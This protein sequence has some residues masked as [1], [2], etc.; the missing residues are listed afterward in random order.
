MGEC[1]LHPQSA[2]LLKFNLWQA[3]H[4]QIAQRLQLNGRIGSSALVAC[5]E[6]MPTSRGLGQ[7]S[8]SFSGTRK[9]TL[10]HKNS[11]DHLGPQEDFVEHEKLFWNKMIMFGHIRML[12][13]DFNFFAYCW[14]SWL[15]QQF[16]PGH[17]EEKHTA[18]HSLTLTS[19]N[20]FS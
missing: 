11:L 18:G 3:P 12:E 15:A 20:S 4:Q 6:H 5:Q 19:T 2:I 13:H 9:G 14:P 7:K 17:L 8:G 16:L 1:S 10:E